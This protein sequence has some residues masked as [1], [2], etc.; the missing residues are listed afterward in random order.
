MGESV[1]TNRLDIAVLHRTGQRSDGVTERWSINF[2]VDG[3]S[4]RGLLNADNLDLSGAFLAAQDRLP[5]RRKVNAEA[6]E[7]FMNIGT[8]VTRLPLYLCPECGDL[9][10]GALTCDAVRVGDKVVWSRFGFENGYDDAMSE[11]ASYA[12]VGPFEFEVRQYTAAI[13]RA[14]SGKV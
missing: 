13:E 5:R 7:L 10:C 3:H 12:E 4:L 11:F 2:L 6:Q 1:V 8:E 9:G 14:T